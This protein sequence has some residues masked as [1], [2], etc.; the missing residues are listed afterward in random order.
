MEDID[1]ASPTK[2]GFFS[3]KT[4]F[5]S[6]KV[7]A[8]LLGV[9]LCIAL[10]LIYWPRSGP[11]PNPVQ[12]NQ[13]ISEVEA[14]VTPNLADLMN[15][16]EMSIPARD[17]TTLSLKKYGDQSDTTILLLHGVTSNKAQ[18]EIPAN[19]LRRATGYNVITLDFR[20]HGQSGGSRYDV[21]YIGQYED[22][23][24]DVLNA[25]RKLNPEQKLIL[26]GHSMGG[27]VALRYALKGGA[28][29]PSA[30]IL[31]A[32]NFGE[33]PT[34]R[35]DKERDA[36]AEQPK[37]V[38]FDLPRMIGQIMMNT[39]GVHVLDHEPILYFNFPPEIQA[40]SYRSVMSA[41]PI[42]PETA[43]V[44]LGAIDVP[45]LVIIGAEDEVFNAST[46]PEFVNGYSS[47]EARLIVNETHTSILFSE[48]AYQQTKD[49]LDSSKFKNQGD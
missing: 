30:Y 5:T 36:E 21:D 11:F 22:D 37:F 38:Q 49:W 12:P 33:G 34:Q 15:G 3:K 39:I 31:Y 48:A 17:G 14:S 42:R 2:P 8:G 27:G 45:L 35:K 25:L 4:L 23:V 32:P 29:I 18:L 26:S 13:Y 28:S 7:F 20:G 9:Y 40:Y 46:Y 44:A 1:T 16:L 43:D 19:M 6:L 10:G 47:G 41:Q 24:E